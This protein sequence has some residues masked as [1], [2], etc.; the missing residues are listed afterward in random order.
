MISRAQDGVLASVTVYFDIIAPLFVELR[1]NCSSWGREE[2]ASPGKRK[3][4]LGWKN[5]RVIS[6]GLS[7][8]ALP[9]LPLSMF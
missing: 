8:L 9:T 6:L 2:S 7:S 1:E 4:G 5:L 3:K